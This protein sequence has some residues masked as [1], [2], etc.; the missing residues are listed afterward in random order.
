MDIRKIRYFLDLV[1]TL[2]FSTSAQRLGISQPALSKAIQR[3]ETD[4]GGSL[5]RRAGRNSTLTR[6]G[7]SLVPNLQQFVK[8]AE[9]RTDGNQ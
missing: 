8:S 7:Q 5:F 4:F 1:E 6:F 9:A 2:N 3:L